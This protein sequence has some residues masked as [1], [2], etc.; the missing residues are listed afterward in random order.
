MGDGE[1]AAVDGDAIAQCDEG[2][3]G[4]G[5]EEKAGAGVFL[6]EGEDGGGGFDEAGE[7]GVMNGGV[8]GVPGGGRGLDKKER[9]IG[10]RGR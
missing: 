5:V 9:R 8:R 1:A 6:F 10:R 2:G 7:H 3:E 4:R